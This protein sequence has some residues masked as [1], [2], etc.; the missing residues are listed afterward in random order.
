MLNLVFIGLKA[1][2]NFWRQKKALFQPK[3]LL[4]TIILMSYI[5]FVKSQ[6]R[7]LKGHSLSTI[8][9]KS[10][11]MYVQ[12]VCGINQSGNK[13]IHHLFNVPAA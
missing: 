1:E 11:I 10:V 3:M 5:R 2:V 6:I 7:K 9:G 13:N 8:N 4:L 12:L